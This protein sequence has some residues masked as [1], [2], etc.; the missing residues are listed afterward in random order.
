MSPAKI[1]S[2]ILQTKTKEKKTHESS[3]LVVGLGQID[4]AG[5][6][7]TYTPLKT[8]TGLGKEEPGDAI[9]FFTHKSFLQVSW[10]YS[11]PVQARTHCLCVSWNLNL[12]IVVT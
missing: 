2:I 12:I 7:P 3:L 6:N 1:F 10:N 8:L 5:T 11:V 9:Y 4:P